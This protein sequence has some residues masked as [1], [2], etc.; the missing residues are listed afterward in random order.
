MKVRLK[1][2]PINPQVLF[3]MFETGTSWRVEAGIPVNAELRGFTIDPN[4][5]CLNLF[6]ESD[7][8][9]AVDI[10]SEVAPTLQTLFKKI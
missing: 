2:I 7:T 10:D 9:D 3:H 8:F 5:Q 1:R 6:I 4:T